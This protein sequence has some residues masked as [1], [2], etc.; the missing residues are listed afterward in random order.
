MVL[1]GLRGSG[2]TTTGKAL[3]RLLSFP[4]HDSDE[5]ISRRWGETPGEILELH[6]EAELRRRERLAVRELA[7]LSTGILALGGGVPAVQANREALKGWPAMLL[8]APDA[9]LVER[10]A[11]DAL[12]RPRLT[13]LSPL[14]EM[15]ELRRRRW[16]DF[17][18]LNPILV[19]STAGPPLAIAQQIARLLQGEGQEK[20]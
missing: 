18:A 15:A 13:D 3:A 10:V 9:V 7:R 16:D 11:R 14:E 19:D 17:L 6:G 20:K 8:D 4:F 12:L 5:F 1:I 2:K